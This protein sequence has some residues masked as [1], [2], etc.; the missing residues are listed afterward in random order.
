VAVIILLLLSHLMQSVRD[1]PCSG[2]Q[3]Q[4]SSSSKPRAVYDESMVKGQTPKYLLVVPAFLSINL[5]YS[6]SCRGLQ[7][8]AS[9][10]QTP[11]TV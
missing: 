8:I 2:S 7:I 9:V 3:F 1:A 10:R 11:C 4:V 5:R 6:D